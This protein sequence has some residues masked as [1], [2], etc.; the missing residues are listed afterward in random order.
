MKTMPA[1]R[2]KPLKPLPIAH[3]A[4]PAPFTA[5]HATAIQA[6]KAGV[7]SEGQQRAALDWILTGACGLSDWP[8][9]ESD[10][11]TCI[12]LGR[13]FVGQ[14]IVGLL[15]VNVTALRQRESIEETQNV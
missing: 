10:R 7:A 2:K 12:A 11:E 5:M 9:R 1:A 13:Q 6:L 4:Q 3:G 14:Q 15:N 8:Y